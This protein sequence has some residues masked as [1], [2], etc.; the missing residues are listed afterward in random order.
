MVLQWQRVTIRSTTRLLEH[1]I[2]LAFTRVEIEKWRTL[3]R[4]PRGWFT[5]GASKNYK[6]DRLTFPWSLCWHVIASCFKALV[7]VI[8]KELIVFLHL[9]N[10]LSHEANWERAERL[11]A[12]VPMTISCCC[13]Y[14]WSPQAP[15]GE[16]EKRLRT[17]WG[18]CKVIEGHPKDQYQRRDNGVTV[19]RTSNLRLCRSDT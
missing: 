5:A 16:P 4:W 19:G 3:N 9:L 7:C 6:R 15:E 2:Q 13:S 12:E 18:A 1:Q 17:R 11:R 14:C 8:P 10:A